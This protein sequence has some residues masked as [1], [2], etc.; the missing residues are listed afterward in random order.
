MRLRPTT[1]VTSGIAQIQETENLNAMKRVLAIH[2]KA[3]A[4]FLRARLC[5]AENIQVN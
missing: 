4:S 2:P 1:I 3:T 5:T